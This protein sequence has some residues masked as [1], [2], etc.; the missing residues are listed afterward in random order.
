[1]EHE[2]ACDVPKD[3]LD[4]EL[5]YDR[6]NW[7]L[8]ECRYAWIQKPADNGSHHQVEQDSDDAAA[9]F[10]EVLPQLHFAIFV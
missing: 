3:E 10:R 5:V 7:L 9:Q 2:R 6:L 1:L 4:V 8:N